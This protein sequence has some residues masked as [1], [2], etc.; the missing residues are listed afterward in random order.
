MPL[1]AEKQAGRDVREGQL[2]QL[3]CPPASG[4]V[5]RMALEQA[6]QETRSFVWPLARAERLS[7]RSTQRIAPESTRDVSSSPAPSR[8]QNQNPFGRCPQPPACGRESDPA[9]RRPGHRGY[10]RE[11]L[12]P[13]LSVSAVG[14]DREA[15]PYPTSTWHEE[16]APTVWPKHSGRGSPAPAT[17]PEMHWAQ[18]HRSEERQRIPWTCIAASHG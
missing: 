14:Q 2:P 12:D 16:K 8:A 18:A 15:R 7:D 5:A 13:G 1:A 10:A 6:P 3:I 4:P 11:M 9:P 17:W